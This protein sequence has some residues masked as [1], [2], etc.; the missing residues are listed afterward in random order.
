[1]PHYPRSAALENEMKIAKMLSEHGN[2]FSAMMECEHCGHTAKLTS[3]Y[4]DN[5]YHARVI[6][7]M[8]CKE[9]GK[10]RAGELEHTDAGVSPCAA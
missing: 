6:P 9:C 4:H 8:R 10:N 1:M 3:G 5:H 7:A 2:D